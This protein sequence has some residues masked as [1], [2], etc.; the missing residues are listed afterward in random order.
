MKITTALSNHQDHKYGSEEQHR[1]YW[2]G[3]SPWKPS[4]RCEPGSVNSYVNHPSKTGEKHTHIIQDLI[5]GHKQESFMKTSGHD[6]PTPN[7][8]FFTPDRAEIHKSNEDEHH[9]EY[10]SQDIDRRS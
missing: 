7:N 9:D 8:N 5:K 6:S 3:F 4:H 1:C 10:K 2:C